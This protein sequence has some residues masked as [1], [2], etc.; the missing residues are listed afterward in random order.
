MV[1]IWI[2]NNIFQ[3]EKQTSF[4]LLKVPNYEKN[5]LKFFINILKTYGL[6]QQR[7]N[8]I[9]GIVESC[10]SKTQVL[11]YQQEQK[12]QLRIAK[13]KPQEIDQ[14][15]PNTKLAKQELQELE[16]QTLDLNVI[17]DEI[18][19]QNSRGGCKIVT[20]KGYN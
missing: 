4:N 17:K 8:N 18:E 1:Q 5:S 3:I 19:N 15:N 2:H 11:T 20:R 7:A 14:Q 13:E 16:H 12:G 9:K 10:R 6:N